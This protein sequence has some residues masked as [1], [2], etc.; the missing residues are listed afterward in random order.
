MYLQKFNMEAI[1]MKK[2]FCFTLILMLFLF[3]LPASAKMKKLGQAGMS[4]LNIDGSARAAAMAG[5]FGAAKNDLGSVFYNPA[6]LASV[7]GTAFFLNSTS[8]I[9]DTKVAHIAVSHNAGKFG[10]F[11]LALQSMDYGD[12]NGTTISES[13]ERGYSDID[14]GD[15][16]GISLGLAYGISMT[17]KFS[18]GG[19]IK[20]VSQNLGANDTYIGDAV[21]ETGKEN[22]TSTVAY[23]F[24]TL[25]DTGIKSIQLTMAIRNYSSQQLY[26]NEEFQI[27]QTYRIGIAANLFEFLPIGDPSANSLV[28]AVEGVDATDR[29]EYMNTGLEYSLLGM[30]DLRGGYSFQRSED[31]TGG[32]NAG[33]GL[34][35]AN[36]GLPIDGRLDIS[37]SDYGSAFGS[38]MRFS[39]Q[40]SF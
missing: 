39:L 24:G 8:W 34:N 16:G 17:D 22:K 3:S 7:E 12:F 31:N 18:I 14:V 21:K 2:I 19:S 25:Y 1:L 29:I 32:L 38:V 26:E 20:M 36:F 5:V 10:V 33:A 28:L 30:I 11:G 23:D 35:M 6:G 9:V 40:G 27:P 4:F 13:D 15:V 37:Y